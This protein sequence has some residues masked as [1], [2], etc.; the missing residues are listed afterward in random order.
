MASGTHKLVWPCLD[1]WS[2]KAEAGSLLDAIV[3][4]AGF[5]IAKWFQLVGAATPQAAIMQ[6]WLRTWG[7]DLDATTADRARRNLAS[8]RPSELMPAV[9]V[10]SDQVLAFFE[11]LWVL[12]EPQPGPSRFPNMENR[13]L[14]DALRISAQKTPTAG[15]LTTLGFELAEATNWETFFSSAEP[16][17]PILEARGSASVDGA[18][19]HL[20]VLSRAA[21]LLFVA[22]GAVRH[23]FKSGSISAAN[24]KFW[25]ARF[26]EERLLWA[27]NDMPED[28]FDLWQD[29]RTAMDDLL[30]WQS[31]RGGIPTSLYTVSME[32]PLTIRRLTSFETVSLWSLLP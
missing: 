17:S 27:P 7:V 24:L 22:S 23:H 19:C 8:Y 3:R 16:S 1:F 13:L 30:N 9:N 6:S 2:K 11:S 29:I 10:S 12:F 31:T 14:R 21:L 15:D 20:Q 18:R 4:P 28:P 32:L 25:V 5:T 26:G